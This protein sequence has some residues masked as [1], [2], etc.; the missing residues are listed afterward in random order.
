MPAY[1]ETNGTLDRDLSEIVSD[2]DI[3]HGSAASS[4]VP[5]AWEERGLF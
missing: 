5:P 1:L 3:T 4:S 2:V